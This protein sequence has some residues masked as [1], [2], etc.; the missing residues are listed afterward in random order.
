MLENGKALVSFDNVAM[1]ARRIEQAA[2]IYGLLPAQVQSAR[3]LVDGHD[4][5]A[6][7]D[8]LGVSV[9]SGRTCSGC[10]TGPACAAK[11]RWRGCS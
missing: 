5:A 6:A 4:L 11:R 10:L 8:I 1:I 7:S 2:T 3:L 9:S